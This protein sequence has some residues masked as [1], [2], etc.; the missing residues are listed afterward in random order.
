MGP[1]FG[2]AGLAEAGLAQVAC[3]LCLGVLLAF[4]TAFIALVFRSR[5]SAGVGVA[6]WVL[7]ALWLQP[8]RDFSAEPSDDPDMQS[9]LAAFRLLA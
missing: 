8:W 2:L 9:F 4:A 1:L 6:I 3:M 7:F 5:I